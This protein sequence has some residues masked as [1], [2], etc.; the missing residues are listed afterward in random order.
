VYDKNWKYGSAKGAKASVILDLIATIYYKTKY[1][2]KG[3]I[4]VCN[5][6]WLLIRSI[7]STLLK[8]N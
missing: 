7:N 4:T 1:I 8:E 2:S 6:N 5:D 3:S